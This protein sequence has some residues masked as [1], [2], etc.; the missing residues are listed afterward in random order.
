M[1]RNFILVLIAAVYA[2]SLL[3]AC[4]DRRATGVSKGSDSTLTAEYVSNISLQEPERALALID[5]MEMRKKENQF[6]INFLRCAVYLNGFN[7]LNM[8]YY[9]GQQAMKDTLTMQKDVKHHYTLLKTLAGIAQSTKQYAQSIKYAKAAIELA[10]KI[11][12]KELGIAATEPLA[13]SLIS[14]GDIDEGFGIFAEGKNV[15]MA[16]L[17]KNPNNQTSNIAYSFIGNYMGK[18]LSANRFKE[19]E[20]LIPDLKQIIDKLGKTDNGMYG[21]AELQRLNINGLFIEYYDKTGNRKEAEKYLA[22]ILNSPMAKANA[23]DAFIAQH[24]YNV[25]DLKKLAE[26]TKRMRQNAMAANDTISEIF[27]ESVLNYEKFICKE[28]GNYREALAKAETIKNIS[29]SLSKQRNEEDGVRQAKIFEIEEKEREIA[30]KNQQLNKQKNA[31][32]T[33]AFFLFV[34]VILIA[35]MVIYNRKLNKRNKTI[36]NTINNIIEK[37]D[38]L[39]RLRM[40]NAETND[41]EKQE[42]PEELR[43]LMAANMMRQETGKSLSDIAHEC[44]FSNTESLCSKFKARFGIAPL[45]YIKWSIKI[46]ESEELKKE[47]M[48]KGTESE[49]IKDNFIRN[50]SH[51]IR[52]PLNQINGFIQI[53]TD[54]RSNLREEERNQFSSIVFEQTLYMT[55]ML[56]TFIEMSEYESDEQSHHIEQV[57]V[58]EI[59][60]EVKKKCTKPND[61]VQMLFRNISGVETIFTERKGIVRILLCLIDNAVKFT[62]QGCIIVECTQDE[63]NST[64]FTVTDTGRGVPSGEGEHIFERFFKINE[65]TPGPGLG[66]SLSRLIAKRIDAEV[67]LDRKY[68]NNGSRFTIKIPNR[69]I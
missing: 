55:N 15:I 24:Y 46:G 6:T 51:E 16:A 67:Y 52:T 50:M 60:E 35:A 20:E 42:N 63:D 1:K 41:D 27:I 56:N 18:L 10:R 12:N 23:T 2:M 31:I 4:S 64:I 7:D 36:V 65:F 17:D 49:R 37:Q 47:M 19:A 61:G 13:L 21:A 45:D 28:Q 43:I 32:K 22:E 62:E 11:K 25:K 44:G 57:F 54:P 59:L 58:D 38:E 53:L 40:G 66:L 33:F 29:D 48:K 3:V 69:T 14:L 34:T 9:Y 68:K 30:Y 5:T 26:V 39:T 8:A